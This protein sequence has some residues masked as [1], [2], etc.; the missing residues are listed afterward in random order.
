MRKQRLPPD[1]R[2]DPTLCHLNWPYRKQSGSNSLD[3]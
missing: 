2:L 3:N 1:S